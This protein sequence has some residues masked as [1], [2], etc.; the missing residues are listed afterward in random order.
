[1]LQDR[2]FRRS[3]VSV[4]VRSRVCPTSVVIYLNDSNHPSNKTIKAY[5]LKKNSECCKAH[6]IREGNQCLSTC[7][8]NGFIFCEW[9]GA[10]PG[11][12]YLLQSLLFVISM[13][14]WNCYRDETSLVTRTLECFINLKISSP[15]QKYSIFDLLSLLQPPWPVVAPFY[16]VHPG[17][18]KL[19]SISIAHLNTTHTGIRI[20]KVFIADLAPGTTL[21]R[22][23]PGVPVP[24][25]DLNGRC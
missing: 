5:I 3:K 15:L 7:L 24:R 8:S 22:P 17:V 12:I 20:T 4:K 10:W 16:F 13:K 6:C 9:V 23:N 25:C 1:M 11:L 14:F 18:M 2:P 21:P 19:I